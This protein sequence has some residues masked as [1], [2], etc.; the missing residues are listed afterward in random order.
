[1]RSG[2]SSPPP[3]AGVCS[4]PSV[5]DNVVGTVLLFLADY[6]LQVTHG[7][8]ERGELLGVGNSSAPALTSA[9]ADRQAVSAFANMSAARGVEVMGTD[10][11]LVQV[12][13]KPGEELSAEPGSVMLH[14][15]SRSVLLASGRRHAG[16]QRLLAG[17]ALL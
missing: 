8:H 6:A 10:A 9:P 5:A 13:L 14:V 4:A 11:Q 12:E 2:A 15:R 1:M 16:I 3:S 17:R 7:D